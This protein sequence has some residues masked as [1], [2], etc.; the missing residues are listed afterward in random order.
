MDIIELDLPGVKLL[1]P[2]LHTDERGFFAELYGAKVFSVL[3]IDTAFVQDSVSRSDKNVIRGLHY[4]R[5][6]YAQAKLVR[7]SSGEIFD[8]VADIDPTAPTFGRFVFA[9]LTGDLQNMLYIPAGYAH[10][11][12][13]LS[14]E[15][16][17]EY[18]MSTGYVSEASAGILY[19]DPLLS[20]P[21]PVAEPVL[22]P[23]DRSWPTLRDDQKHAH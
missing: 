4:Q 16:V 2:A 5:P 22:S 14:E 3:G 6:P 20:I 9:R 1:T 15:A 13:V 17:V 8:V 21:W 11:F 12:C 7:C 10:G 18:K 19:N 23:R